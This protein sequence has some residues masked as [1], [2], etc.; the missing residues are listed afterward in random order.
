MRTLDDI[1]DLQENSRTQIDTS[2]CINITGSYI[3]KY[4]LLN[5]LC[6]PY[7]LLNIWLISHTYNLVWV[8]GYNGLKADLNIT[9]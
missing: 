7:M 9:K 6:E 5:V 1:D 2:V 3:I 4:P 8:D